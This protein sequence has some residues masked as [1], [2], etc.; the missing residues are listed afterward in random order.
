MLPTLSGSA[1][2]SR[3]L[4]NCH[5]LGS[6][7]AFTTSDPRGDFR[8]QGRLRSN[9]LAI[10][11]SDAL[12]RGYSDHTILGLTDLSNARNVTT[13]CEP[14]FAEFKGIHT[15]PF[16]WNVTPSMSL[17]RSRAGSVLDKPTL[18]DYRPFFTGAQDGCP[19]QFSMPG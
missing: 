3:C 4:S 2:G 8:Y 19:I 15:A 6:A 9:L 18:Y 12:T 16:G 13:V 1:L 14:A 10:A 5:R 17:P 11:L 7:L